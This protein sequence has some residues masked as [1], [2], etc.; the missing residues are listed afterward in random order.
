MRV[1]G[2]RTE[3][4]TT[5]LNKNLKK[6]DKILQSFLVFIQQFKKTEFE[7]MHLKI[8]HGVKC[9][10]RNLR[11]NLQLHG[12]RATVTILFGSGQWLPQS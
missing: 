2:R 8:N 5:D 7:K 12:R 4:Q 6:I 11:F 10:W 9:N 1:T 3:K